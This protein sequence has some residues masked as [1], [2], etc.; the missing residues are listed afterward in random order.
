LFNSALG[1]FKQSKRI[2]A[3]TTVLPIIALV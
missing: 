1:I 2:M 3:I